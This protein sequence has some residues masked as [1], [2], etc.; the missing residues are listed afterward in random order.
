M[1][2]D[3]FFTIGD[4]HF[5]CVVDM[6]GTW[7]FICTWNG[8]EQEIKDKEKLKYNIAEEKVEKVETKENVVKSEITLNVLKTFPTM[9]H[10][11]NKLA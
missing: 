9:Y 6:D 4:K 11:L 8:S 5:T 1:E 3:E 10:Q 2:K 7:V